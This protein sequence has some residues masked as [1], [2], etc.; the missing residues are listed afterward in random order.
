MVSEFA[1]GILLDGKGKVVFL[2]LVETVQ[3]NG[4]CVLT[5]SR[6]TLSQDEREAVSSK[7]KESLTKIARSTLQGLFNFE[8]FYTR[9]GNV[10]I[11][12]G[13]PRP[14]NSQHLTIDASPVS[15][16]ALLMKYLAGDSTVF[17]L[18]EIPT[19][20]AAMINLLGKS[21]GTEYALTL[22]P[23]P[24]ELEVYPKLYLKKECRPGRKM[25][26]LNL[27]DPSGKLDLI[28]LGEKILKEY[29]L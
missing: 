7:I 27:V 21:L 2:P 8:F 16:F 28:S 12:E 17:S 5:L 14:H 25:G 23:L 22:P 15:Q 10:L 3:E 18:G 13:A 24:A 1:Q 9:D 26:H 20:P 19:R 6:L 29:Q 11:N 4:T